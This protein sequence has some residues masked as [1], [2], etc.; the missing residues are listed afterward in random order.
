MSTRGRRG[1]GGAG[2]SGGPGYRDCRGSRRAFLQA[3]V[4]V[5]RCELPTQSAS[6]RRGARPAFLTFEPSLASPF[7]SPAACSRARWQ[8]VPTTARATQRSSP[9]PLWG[10]GPFLRTADGPG[11]C[12]WPLSSSPCPAPV[13]ALSWATCASPEAGDRGDR[14]STQRPRR[15]QRDAVCSARSQPRAPG[16]PAFLRGHQ[17]CSCHAVPQG[18]CG[19]NRRREPQNAGPPPTC[20]LDSK[21]VKALVRHRACRPLL[22][23]KP[24]RSGGSVQSP[25][26]R[27]GSCAQSALLVH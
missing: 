3:L 1:G 24:R 27:L 12:P 18:P 9:P 19:A 7:R 2:C 6:F 16:R 23:G 22:A 15:R 8:I 20:N 26:R 13:P 10:H 4:C 5:L 14:S 17:M 11:Q 25:C 21:A